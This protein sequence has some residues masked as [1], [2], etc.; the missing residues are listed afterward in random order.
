MGKG[1]LE[2]AARGLGSRVVAHLAQQAPKQGV[3]AGCGCNEL[4]AAASNLAGGARR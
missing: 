2:V 1:E 4:R 3:S